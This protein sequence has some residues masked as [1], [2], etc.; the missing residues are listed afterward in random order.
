MKKTLTAVSMATLMALPGLA[1]ARP[2]RI[3]A[4][5]NT[6]G[7]NPAYFA[8]YLVNSR[9]AY[10]HTLYVAGRNS[11]YYRHLGGWMRASRGH[12]N[13]AGITGASVGSGQSLQ[14]TVDIADSLINAGY[15]VQVDAAAEGFNESPRDVIVPL[16]NR[17]SGKAK[18]GRAYLSSFQLDM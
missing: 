11:R 13:L 18:R 9:G 12:P 3:T 1:H 5:L 2:V 14:V 16:A 15:K 6:Y 7:G 8:V 4:H 17:S 10:D